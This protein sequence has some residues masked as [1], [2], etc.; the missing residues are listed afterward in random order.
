LL[1]GINLIG[2]EQVLRLC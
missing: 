2:F 1:K